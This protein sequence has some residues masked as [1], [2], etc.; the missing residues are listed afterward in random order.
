VVSIK[1]IIPAINNSLISTSLFRTQA[2]A[3]GY[4]L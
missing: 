1:N 3:C 4:F 2:K